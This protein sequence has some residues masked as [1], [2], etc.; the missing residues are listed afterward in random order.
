VRGIV[1]LK[2]LGVNHWISS[3]NLLGLYRDNKFIKHDTDIDVNVSLRWDT[4]ETNVIQMELLSVFFSQ[5]FTLLRSV[6]YK[7]HP[8]Q[9]AYM[10]N[11]TNIIFDMYFFYTG[12]EKG[13]ALN[14]TQS[15]LIRKPLKYIEKLDVLKYGGF[16]FPIP[17][18]IEEFLVW[19]FGENWREPS[20]KKVAWE[21]DATHLEDW[22]EG[23]I[24]SATH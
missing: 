13:H 14:I 11:E 1:I 21:K 4:D 18:H 15:G 2:N 3:G 9:L 12:L 10:D 17:T 7:N 5:N 20:S 24:L 23:N 19:R 8:M 22:D 16:E 6:I